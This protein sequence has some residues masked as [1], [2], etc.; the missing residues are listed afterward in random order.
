MF[1]FSV[2]GSVLDAAYEVKALSG[3]APVGGVAVLRCVVPLTLKNDIR[4]TAW[5]QD[6]TGLIILPSL[7][8]GG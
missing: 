2:G 6:F 8:G 7:Q 4:V 1:Y 5:V 3:T